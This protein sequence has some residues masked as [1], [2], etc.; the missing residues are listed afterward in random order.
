[1]KGKLIYTPLRTTV[2]LVYFLLAAGFYA[3]AYDPTHIA[4]TSPRKMMGK[5]I[6]E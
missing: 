6:G 3:Q 4:F 5:T 2:I 1:M